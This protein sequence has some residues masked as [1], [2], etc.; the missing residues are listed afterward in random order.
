MTDAA[1]IERCPFL[2]PG[3]RVSAHLIGGLIITGVIVG[4]RHGRPLVRVIWEDGDV[5]TF[6]LDAR[7]GDRWRRLR[8]QRA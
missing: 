5:D 2:S 8:R 7:A 4:E 6:E 1:S 3:D